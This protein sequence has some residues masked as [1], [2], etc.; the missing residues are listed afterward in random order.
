MP[1]LRLVF[2]L[3]TGYVGLGVP[4]VSV[5]VVAAVVMGVVVSSAGSVIV[6]SSGQ[7][8][9]SDTGAILFIYRKFY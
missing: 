5:G 2:S 9:P 4:V 7:G 6:V 1:G 8:I 3:S